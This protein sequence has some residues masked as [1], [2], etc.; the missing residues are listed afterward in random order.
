MDRGPG[1]RA[2]DAVEPGHAPPVGIV[3]ALLGSNFS[4]VSGWRGR[5]G[6]VV[7]DAGE[8]ER[9]DGSG[10]GETDRTE[11]GADERA[12]NREAS[13]VVR[14]FIRRSP[15]CPASPGATFV[16]SVA[17]TFVVQNV[18]YTCIASEETST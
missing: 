17:A 16:S 2:S 1:T 13:G 8:L 12:T 11:D 10:G 14:G 7:E 4:K 5:A 15:F 18:R 9:D 3:V 6:E